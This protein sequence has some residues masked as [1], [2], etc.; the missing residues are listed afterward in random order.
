M[1]GGIKAAIAFSVANYTFTFFVI[2]LIVTLQ[3]R[4]QQ[5]AFAK[6]GF[7]TLQ[8][9]AAHGQPRWPLGA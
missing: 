4:L 8:A 3:S 5:F 6:V 1:S 2:G 7:S 9:G